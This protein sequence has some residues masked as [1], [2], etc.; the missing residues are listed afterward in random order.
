VTKRSTVL[1]VGL[2]LGAVLLGVTQ[3]WFSGTVA[4]AT[5]GTA[6]VTATGAQAAPGA[7]AL[8]LVV[9]AALLAL[10]TSG[11]RGRIVAGVLLV[12]ASLGAGWAIAVALADRAG[13]LGARAAEQAG[14]VGGHSE[15]AASITPW[16][17]VAAAGGVA[18]V[19]AS[20]AAAWGARRWAG[21]SDRFERPSATGNAAESPSPAA[22]A[23]DE[24]GLRRTAWDE[25]SEGHDPTAGDTADDTQDPT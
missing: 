9:G 5:L 21:L 23:S 14:R 6:R 16:A 3:P 1:A 11:P 25:L 24:R 15:V 4:D 7:L 10:M 2:P 18:L 22:T 13:L 8:G 12:G 19:V 17:W 20:S